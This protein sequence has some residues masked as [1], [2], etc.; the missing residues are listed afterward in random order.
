ME[1]RLGKLAPGFLA[2]L[3]VL[4][5]DIFNIDPERIRDILP[6]GTMISGDWVYLT[7]QLEQITSTS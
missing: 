6:L 2:D 1:N 3:L 7:P 4:D 5:Q